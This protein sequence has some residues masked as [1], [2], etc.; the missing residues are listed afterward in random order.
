MN[1]INGFKLLFFPNTNFSP[2]FDNINNNYNN[3]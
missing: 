2:F 1:L 3:E